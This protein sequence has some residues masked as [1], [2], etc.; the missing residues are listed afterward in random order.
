MTKSFHHFC[1]PVLW[2]FEVTQEGLAKQWP[3]VLVQVNSCDTWNRH[4]IQGYGFLKIPNTSGFK[5]IKVRTWRPM[6]SNYNETHSFFLGG[7]TRIE[8]PWEL[9]DTYVISEEGEKAPVNRFGL[10]TRG[11]GSV[12]F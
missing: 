2:C 6:E 9:S 12:N 1:F 5:K 4:R 10:L 3:E 8:N 11:S 7:S